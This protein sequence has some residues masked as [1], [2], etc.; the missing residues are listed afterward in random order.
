MFPLCFSVLGL[1]SPA[2]PVVPLRPGGVHPLTSLRP[3]RP[4]NHHHRTRRFRWY[5]T[6][7]GSLC[8]ALSVGVIGFGIWCDLR[9]DYMLGTPLLVGGGC[10]LGCSVVFTTGV[11]Y[12]F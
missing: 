11:L 5:G 3:R 10:V 8:T 9:T 2:S 7:F 12:L 6:L 4:A 1:S